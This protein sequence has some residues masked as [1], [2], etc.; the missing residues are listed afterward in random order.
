[1]I[2]ITRDVLESYI[3]CHYKAYLKLADQTDGITDG[4]TL[5]LDKKL[6]Y[7]STSEGAVRSRHRANQ[8]TTS[9]KLTSSYLRKGKAYILDG[10][11]ETDLISLHIDGLQRV[12]GSSDLGDFHYLP[13]V[14]KSGAE[15]HETQ[16]VLLEVYGSILSRLQGRVPDKGIIWTSE[17]K[18]STIQ[19][20]AGLRRGERILN[21]VKEIQR[22]EQTPILILNKHCQTCEFQS[23]CHTQAVEEDNLSLLRG[24]SEAEILRLKKRG[25]L[26]INQLSY[27]FRPRHIKK[28]AKNPASS[29]F[30][31]PSTCAS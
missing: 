23:R 12:E 5:L 31:T 17:E 4:R 19:L 9:V 6:Q 25:I 14:S 20:T 27:T 22:G 21:A 29:L 30:C 24:I 11:F 15:V 7:P 16:R 10:L 28:R 1:M 18:F 13:F 8:D 26:T 3:A 2:I